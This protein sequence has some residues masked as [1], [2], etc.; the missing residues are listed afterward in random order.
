MACR[1]DDMH[2]MSGPLYA[3]QLGKNMSHVSECTSIGSAVFEFCL[4]VGA[5]KSVRT[6]GFLSVPVLAWAAFI[7]VPEVCEDGA[8]LQPSFQRPRRRYG[9]SPLE[10][11]ET[12]RKRRRKPHKPHGFSLPF[13]YSIMGP[14]RQV[15]SRLLLPIDVPCPSELHVTLGKK[16][17][18]VAV[19]VR[20]E[21]PVGTHGVWYT[22]GQRYQ[23]L[24]DINYTYGNPISPFTYE[25]R[26]CEAP[27]V[28]EFLGEKVT[29]AFH[30]HDGNLVQVPIPPR[31]PGRF[32]VIG[33]TGLRIKAENDGW[34][35]EN[36]GS[37]KDLYGAKTCPSESVLT[38][39]N[40]TLVEGLF[41]STSREADPALNGWPFQEI[42]ESVQKSSHY[43]DVM[44][45]VG[46]YLYSH[47]A[48]PFPFPDQIPAGESRV[49]VVVSNIF[50]FHPY[51]GK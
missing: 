44:V 6:L 46:D 29:A 38:Y 42:C 22:E 3:E 4:P 34:C 35:D 32:L 9:F 48:C 8:L 7:E 11:R 45:H 41:Q 16:K 5:M 23:H 20:A 2:G 37:P 15:V 33:D 31:Q 14:G 10:H 36:L 12:W 26:I 13:G 18:V 25:D 40:A 28:P 1:C 17:Q 47:N 50:Y 43:G 21:P 24:T 49:W 27:F 30:L 39:Y 51:L 19:H